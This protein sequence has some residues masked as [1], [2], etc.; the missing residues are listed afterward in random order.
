LAL[1]MAHRAPTG[2]SHLRWPIVDV[3]FLSAML[4]ILV[5]AH[6]L[7]DGT[8]KSCGELQAARIVQQILIPDEIP[9]IPGFTIQ[10]C[11]IL[12]S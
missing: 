11:Y 10:S 7:R 9:A 6:P 2:S 5:G 4:A 3:I 8:K 1:P 12:A